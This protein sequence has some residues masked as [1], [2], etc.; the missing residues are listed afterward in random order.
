MGTQT[1]CQYSTKPKKQQSARDPGSSHVVV[2]A[3][4]KLASCPNI[5]NP[6][7]VSGELLGYVGLAPSGQ[8]HHHNHS[9]G[10]GDVG[11]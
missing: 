3:N 6:V 8:T 9:V 10:I 5:S 1:F 7:Q 2:N 4:G 11:T